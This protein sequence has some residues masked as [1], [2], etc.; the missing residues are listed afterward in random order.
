MGST[1]RGGEICS[2]PMALVRATREG[3]IDVTLSTE[4]SDMAGLKTFVSSL[5]GHIATEAARAL[6]NS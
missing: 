6:S 5:A 2:G 1:G 4:L 3:K